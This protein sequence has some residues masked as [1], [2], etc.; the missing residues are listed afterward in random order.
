MDDDARDDGLSFKEIMSGGG[1]GAAQVE[2]QWRAKRSDL[3][4]AL[5][6]DGHSLTFTNTWRRRDEY[7]PEW[8]TTMACEECDTRYRGSLARRWWGLSPKRPCAP[9]P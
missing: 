3:I 9:H 6:A 7:G 2:E 8:V 1:A 5:K 4:E